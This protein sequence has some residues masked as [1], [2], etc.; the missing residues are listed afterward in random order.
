M[1]LLFKAYEKIKGVV[2]EWGDQGVKL[3]PNL[4]TAIIILILFYIVS[5][6]I[7]K[8]LGKYLRKKLPGSTTKSF[9]L[10]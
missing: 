5:K 10:I 3:I 2:V 1:D 4:I 6:F 8:K 7:T 9:Q